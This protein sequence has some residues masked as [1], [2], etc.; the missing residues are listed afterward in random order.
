MRQCRAK[1][2]LSF[3]FTAMAVLLV[4]QAAAALVPAGPRTAQWQLIG[5]PGGEGISDIDVDSNNSL[6]LYAATSDGVYRSTDGG[7]SWHL[8]IGGFFRDLVIDPQNS[9]VIYTGPCDD[10]YRYGVFKSTD[11]GDSWTRYDEGMTCTNLA[12]LAIAA[13]DPD[14]L[15]TGSF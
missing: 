11:G 14:I 3:V 1:H 10:S 9:D 12:T 8:S 2:L 4:G 13:S 15:F 6:R 7:A 5:P